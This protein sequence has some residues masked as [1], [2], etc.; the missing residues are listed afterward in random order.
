M[1][2]QSDENPV[3]TRLQ[4]LSDAWKLPF[5]ACTSLLPSAA[6]EVPRETPVLCGLAPAGREVHT[7]Q[8]A[9]HRGE[10]VQRTLLLA[11]HLGGFEP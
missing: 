6:G 4:A 1:Q 2:R 7:P 5:A 11:L 8:E 9:V 3:L 10:L